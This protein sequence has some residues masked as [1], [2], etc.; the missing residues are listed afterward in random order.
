MIDK[1][2]ITMYNEWKETRRIASIMKCKVSYDRRGNKE[3]YLIERENKSIV[4]GE[5]YLRSRFVTNKGKAIGQQEIERL[6]KGESISIKQIGHDIR[7]RA[8]YNEL[9]DRYII[10]EMIDGRVDSKDL[11]GFVFRMLYNTRPFAGMDNTYTYWTKEC[12][13]KKMVRCLL[14]CSNEKYE[15]T[16]RVSR[17]KDRLKLDVKGYSKRDKKEMGAHIIITAE[18][19]KSDKF[20]VKLTYEI[21]P[22]VF[23]SRKVQ[24]VYFKKLKGDC[25]EI[26]DNTRNLF[27]ITYR[28]R[29]LLKSYADKEDIVRKYSNYKWLEKPVEM[30]YK[31][32]KKGMIME[33][34]YGDDDNVVRGIL[35]KWSVTKDGKEIE[36][37][38]EDMISGKIEKGYE[39]M[40]NKEPGLN[41]V[42]VVAV[43]KR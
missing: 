11:G 43:K 18:D 15:Y 14:T 7:V 31:D 30:Y 33:F 28:L 3:G 24:R 13:I 6:N 39:F 12:I 22:S 41:K 21:M 23:S 19:S 2:V 40:Y 35:V 29:A 16:G 20:M 5:E 27:G 4:V 10:E 37:V 42:K 38:W 34:S 17:D 26:N 8:K 36:T 25:K 9:E 1:G 32:L